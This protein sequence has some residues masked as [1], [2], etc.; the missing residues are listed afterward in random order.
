MKIK[1][2]VTMDDLR[3]FNEYVWLNSPS[4]QRNMRILLLFIVTLWMSI[5]VYMGYL[6]GEWGVP[7]TIGSLAC[8]GYALIF[9]KRWLK[10]SMKSAMKIYR[11]GDNKNM[12]GPHEFETAEEYLVARSQLSDGRIQWNG[13]DKIVETPTHVLI[14]LGAVSAYVINR[15]SV[16]E[17]DLDAFLAEVKRLWQSHRTV[18]AIEV[19]QR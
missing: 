6:F 16:M 19:S 15:G 12:L 7:L 2:D 10:R 14:F 1:Y 3:F 9:K 4:I 5:A 8:I 13:V 11:E 18:P 17:G